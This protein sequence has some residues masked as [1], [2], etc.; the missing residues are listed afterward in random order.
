MYLDLAQNPIYFQ[1]RQPNILI[2]IQTLAS[3]Q[4]RIAIW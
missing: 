3:K 2:K 4:S 1:N